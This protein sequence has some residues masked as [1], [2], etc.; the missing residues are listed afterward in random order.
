MILSIAALV[1]AEAEPKKKESGPNPGGH[2][3]VG[4]HGGSLVGGH[5]GYAPVGYAKTS[6]VI[7]PAQKTVTVQKAYVPTYNEIGEKI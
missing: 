4:G 6:S 2:S 1:S 7:L 5:G 3:L